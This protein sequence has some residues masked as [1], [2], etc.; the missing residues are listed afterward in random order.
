[1]KIEFLK[2]R[3]LV[4]LQIRIYSGAGEFQG[5]SEDQSAHCLCFLQNTVL[6]LFLVERSFA[7]ALI[8]LHFC[9]EL[10][11]PVDKMQFACEFFGVDLLALF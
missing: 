5:V 4:Y 6:R 2:F 8:V 9:S 11:S 7:V 1:M 10:Y 3:I